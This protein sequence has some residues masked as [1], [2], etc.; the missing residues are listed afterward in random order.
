MNGLMPGRQQVQTII[1]HENDV[2]QETPGPS[3]AKTT[4]T[5]K[6][7][8]NKEIYQTALRV[9]CMQEE[10]DP[11]DVTEEEKQTFLGVYTKMQL[12]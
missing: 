2:E 9:W 6:L 11:D 4:K 12:T 1:K 5:E 8:K 10:I 3:T 7:R